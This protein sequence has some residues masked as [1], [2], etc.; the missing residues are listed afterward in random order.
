MGGFRA[1]RDDDLPDD[2]LD[3]TTTRLGAPTGSDPARGGRALTTPLEEAVRRALDAPAEYPASC[4][5]E[6]PVV[7]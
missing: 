2:G 1:W 3:V 7:F 5:P 6:G 4:T